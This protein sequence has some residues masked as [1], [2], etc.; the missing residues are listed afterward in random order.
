[1]I[2]KLSQL[3]D[4]TILI[5][6]TVYATITED[7]IELSCDEDILTVSELEEM[8]KELEKAQA[9]KALNENE[10]L[11]LTEKECQLRLWQLRR[12]AVIIGCSPLVERL[13]KFRRPFY[14]NLKEL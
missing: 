2:Y 14:R 9:K 8:A 4:G 6:D 1:M 10:W 7:N 11:N 3:E 12:A 13:R 5:N